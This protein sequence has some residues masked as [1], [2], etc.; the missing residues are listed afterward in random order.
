MFQSS[1]WVLSLLLMHENK[2]VGHI[3]ASILAWWLSHL[4]HTCIIQAQVYLRES[5]KQWLKVDVKKIFLYDNLL[6]DE[7]LHHRAWPLEWKVTFWIPF[8][9]LSYIR[10]E[11]KGEH[12]RMYSSK[13]KKI[14]PKGCLVLTTTSPKLGLN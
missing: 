10:Q 6:W 11:E 12:P 8:L 5:A 13:W 4:T 14:I 3:S 2:Y 1:I 9:E 7:P